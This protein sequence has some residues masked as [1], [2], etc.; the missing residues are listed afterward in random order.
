MA[1]PGIQGALTLGYALGF[2]S[3]AVNNDTPSR[4]QVIVETIDFE[5]HVVV[6]GCGE[7]R[8]DRSSEDDAVTGVQGV[9]H[10]KYFGVSTD[11]DTDAA[12]LFGSQ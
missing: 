10:G 3:D 7:L 2:L 9:V 4:S 5:D 6:H 8:A 11:D 1:T 12:D